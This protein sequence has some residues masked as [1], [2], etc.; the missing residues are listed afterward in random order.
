MPTAS[1]YVKDANG[2]LVPAQFLASP[3]GQGYITDLNKIDINP[4]NTKNGH[5]YDVQGIEI[6][7]ANPNNYLVVPVGFNIN[8]AIS[9]GNY[10]AGL[11]TSQQLTVMIGS[12]VGVGQFN[13]QRTYTD[14]NGVYVQGG[15]TVPMFQDASSYILGVASAPSGLTNAAI[16]GGGL[17]NLSPFGGSDLSGTWWNNPR[18]VISINAGANMAGTTFTPPTIPADA[19]SRNSANYI[20]DTSAN[21]HLV[22]IKDGG[23]VWDAYVQQKNSAT[24]FKDWNEY[25]TAA[26]ASNPGIADLNNVPAGTTFM[27]PEKFADGSITYNYAGGAA[28]NSNARTGEYYMVVPNTDDGGGQTVYS[29]TYDGNGLGGEAYTVRQ[30]STDAQGDTTYDFTGRQVG[31]DSDIKPITVIDRVAPGYNQVLTDSNA[32]GKLDIEFVNTDSNA[33]QNGTETNLYTLTTTTTTT[34]LGETLTD[35]TSAGPSGVGNNLLSSGD[36]SAGVNYSLL[37]DVNTTGSNSAYFNY[38]ITDGLRP[39]NSNLGL[40]IN[41]SSGQ[42]LKVPTTGTTLGDY[43]LY[44]SSLNNAAAANFQLT[45]TDPLVLDL[46]GDGVRLTNYSDSAVLFDADNDGGSLEQTGWVSALDGIVVQDL[47]GN[48][49]IDNISETLSEYYNGVA[50]SAGVAGTKPYANGFAALKSLDSNSDNQFTSLDAAWNNLRVW[51]DANHDGKTDAGELKTFA[52]LGITA[53]NLATTAQSGEVRDGNEVLALGSFTQN[54]LSREA[55]AANFLANPAGST[56]TQTG[57][58]I[59]IATE[60]VAGGAGGTGTITSFVSQ[61]TLSTVNETLDAATLGVRHLTGGAGADTLTGDTQNNW[62]AGGLGADKLYGGAG[63]DVLLIDANDAV[64]D[65]GTGLDI[66]QVVGGQLGSAGVTLNLSQSNIEIAVG[67]DG[68]DV[69]IGGGRSSVFVRGGAGD[70]LIIGGAANDV[71]SGED[72]SDL[73]DGGAGNDLIRGHRGQDQ[74]L[75]GAGDDVLDGGLEDDSLSGGVGNDV[76][77]GGRGDDMM[78]GGDGIDVAEYSGSYADYR[79][80]KVSNANGSNTFRVVDTRT[81]QDGADTLSNIEKLSFSDVSRVDLTLGSPLPV[82]DILSVNSTGQALSRT[83]AHLLSKTQLLG[84][85]RDWD[86]DTSQLSITAVLEAKGGT[87]TLTAQG[88]VLFT[89]DATYTGVMGFKYKVQDAQGNYTQVTNSAT[90]QTEAMK[91][92]VYLQTADLP[93]DPLAMEQWYLTDTNVLAAWGTAAEQAAGQGYSGK[94]IKIG[95]FEPGG[96]F[97]TGPEVFDYRHPDLAQNADKAWLNTLDSQGNSNVAQTFSTHATMVA[98]VMVAARNGQGGVGVAYNASLAGQ[99]I[100]GTGLEVSQLTAE[101]T[102]ALAKFKNYDVVNNSWGATSNFQINV[103]PVGLL[104]T[105]ILDAVTNGR[106]GLGTAIVMAGGNDRATGANT[107]TNALTANR[108]VITTGSINAPGDLGTLQIGSKPFSNPGASILVSAPGSNIDSTSRELIG[109]NGSTFGSDYNTAQGTSFAAPI[110]S[111]VIALMLEANPKLG[112]RDIQSI[113]A[114]SAT[115]FDDPNGTDWTYNTA[116]NWN[117]GGMHASHDYGFGKV[118]ARAAVRLAET[119]YDTSIAANEQNKTASSGTINATIPD[120]AGVL[121]QTLAMAAGLDVESAQVTLQLAHQRWGDLII[122]LISPTGTESVLVNRPGKAPGSAA[123]DLGD[124]STGT[125]SFSFN[126]THVRGEASGGNWTLQVLDAATGNTGTLT[127]WK[128]DLYG[129]TADSDDVYVYTNEFAST[130]GRTTLAD[131]NGGIDIVNAS[132]VTGNSTINLNNGTSSTIAGKGLT[133]SGDVEKAYGGDGNDT[134]TGN[135]LTNVLLGGRGNDTLNGGAGTDRLQG[136]RGNDTLTGGTERDWFVIQKDAGS[137]DTITD[138]T[139]TEVGEKIALVGFENVT[140]FSQVIVTQEGANTRLNLGGGQSVLLLNLAPSQISEQNFVFSSDDAS[141]DTYLTYATKALAYGTV[142]VDNGLLPNTAGDLAM[143]ALAGDDVLGAQTTNDLIDGG[144]GND[145]LWGDYPGY[146]PV[147]GSDW[148]EGGAGNDV[149]RGGAGNDRLIGGS[150]NDQLLGEDGDDILIGNT[151]L[152]YIDGGAGNDLIAMEGDTGTVNGTTFGYYGTRV[153]GAGADVFKVLSSGGGSAGFSA[154]GTQ[155]TASNLIAD[156]DPN[157]AGEKIDVSAF[158]WITN[159]SD[160]AIQNMTINGVQFARVSVSNGSQSLN[161]T[162]R[163]VTSSQLNASHFVFAASTPGAING[164]IS[165]DTLTGDAGANTINGMAGADSMT[166]RTGDDTYFVDNVGD[167]IN[168]LPGGGYDGV[169]SSVSYALSSDVEVLTLTGSAD[170]NAT[171]NAQRNRLVGN[172]GANRLDG[173]SEADDMLGDA[174][175]DAYVVDNQLDTAYENANE[176]IDVVESSVSWT[177]GSNFENLTLTGAGNINATGNDV[178]NV[179]T[180]NAADNIL[181]GAQGA[182]TMA[183]GIGN[184]TYYVDNTGDIV[185]EAIDAG[186]D[187]V[188]SSVDQIALAANVENAVLF[189]F[190]TTVNGNALDN[191]LVGNGLANSLSGGAGNDVLDGGTGADI[192][193]G[194]MGDDTFFV[195]NAGDSVVEL[196]GEGTDTV[197]AS[198]DTSLAALSANVENL[199]LTGTNNLSGTGNALANQISGNS[200][201]NT[202]TGGAGNDVLDGGAGADSMVGGI[203]DDTFYVDQSGDLVSESAG[204]GTDLVVSAVTYALGA[205]LENLTLSGFV[206]I[207]ATGNA[208]G[209]ILQGNSASNVL[210]GGAGTDSLRGNGGADTLRGGLDNDTYVF[211]LGDGQD[212]IEENDGTVGNVDTISFA[213]GIVPASITAS[214]IGGDLVLQ[215]SA[216][217]SVTVKGWYTSSAQKIE[218]IFFA[219]SGETLN[220]AQITAL[221]NHTPTGTV[222]IAGTTAQNQ[223][224]TAVNTLADIEGMGDVSYQWQASTDGANWTLIDGATSP[225]LSLTQAH[226]GKQIRVVGSY[227]DGQGAPEFM[228]SS[229][230]TAIVNINDAPLQSGTQTPLAAGVE[231]TSY[232]ITEA[233][234]LAGFTD[235]DGDALSVVDLT[236]SNGTLSAFDAVARSWTFNPNANYNGT[237]DI[238]YGVSDGVATPVA[239]THSFVLTATNDAPTGGV[240]LSGTTTENQTLSATNSLAD[241]DGMGTLG[242]QWQSSGDGVTWLAIS[243]ANASTFTLTGLQVGKQVRVNVNY[244]DGQGTLESITSASTA[245]VASALNYVVG[246]SAADTLTGSVGADSMQGLAGNDTYVVN[247]VGDIVIEALNAGTDIV[248]ASISYALTD[249]VEN[250]TLTGIDAINGTGNTL[251]NAITGNS[252]DNVLDGGL[253]VDTMAGGLGND[254]YYVDNTADVTTEAASAGIDTVI[255]SV[256]RTLATN[257]ENLVLIGTANLNGTGNTLVNTITGNSGNNVLNGGT[258]ADTLIGG[259]GDD[260]YVV[261]NVG[262]TVTELAGEGVDTIQS[263]VTYALGANVENLTLTGTGAINATGN[264]QSNVLLGNAGNNTLDG[265]LG[266]DTMKGGAGNDTYVVEDL[267]DLVTENLN[268]GTDTIKSTLSYVLGANLENL[269]L[270]GVL[271]INATGNELVNTLTGNAGDN[272]LNGMGGADKLLGGLGNDTY[273]IDNVGVVVT[274]SASSGTDTVLAS[275][276]LTLATNVEKLILMGTGNLNGTGNTLANSITG[277]SGNNVLNGGTGADTLTG[278]LGDDTYVV[279]N[280][281]DLVTEFA[282][283]GIDTVQ[284]SVTYTLTA[285]VENMTLTGTSAIQATGNALD[286]IL[287]GNGGNNTLTGGGGNDTLNGGAGT[288]S[289]VGGV[290]S[291]TYQFGLGYGADTITENDATAGN[292][293]VLQFL[294]GIASDQI[295]LRQV[296]NNLE[297]SV[298]GTTDKATVSNWYLGSQYHVEQ[299]KTS[300]GKT[301]LDSQVQN[302]VNAMSAFSPPAVGQTTL[303]ANY[304]TSLQPVITANWQ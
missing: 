251:N 150:G 292:A 217:D 224:L 168:E 218:Q 289:L 191:T 77:I 130:T 63:D 136:G 140:D 272:V 258:G 148:L 155:F 281:G 178:A 160:L 284:S 104:E 99:Y 166:G 268:E 7:N 295:W 232:T 261:D 266:S 73:I 19:P 142:G 231:D 159:L 269:T 264:A 34:A 226:V 82:K 228:N 24:G 198:V 39:G 238:S 171:G 151:G 106:G 237:V 201:N 274:E 36:Y 233:S 162:I 33:S 97:S 277:N 186:I 199:V 122:K 299:F 270:T 13:L 8:T 298:I 62:L 262:D 301:L 6:I 144:D 84:N 111:G 129:A 154:S 91:A 263:S 5:Y 197:V 207:D 135:A 195:D 50:G 275:V 109:D 202:L 44:G 149:L 133:I 222:S 31:L 182:D 37:G 164:T 110:V 139:P 22:V 213:S 156:F 180:G 2:K 15:T 66:A 98:G 85:D 32:D 115:K 141:L 35:S 107:N 172:A 96:A 117:G 153:G 59:T 196:A 146:S 294:S 244:T 56:V 16:K 23:K 119:W 242:Y 49:K 123:T 53:I 52:E 278:G 291:D 138:F 208:V 304:A 118:D 247:H 127:N 271:N 255:S 243:G 214:R 131:S 204:E 92:A 194:G 273:I 40:N 145:T 221:I 215:Y 177:L 279:D 28:I 235:G 58:G 108:A 303:A 254:T 260:T 212:S 276:D 18:N 60:N 205:N 74:L 223:T 280:A 181:D 113:L 9:F 80:T 70:D 41:A 10:V 210:D 286:N 288:D 300:D 30:I 239:A 293:D 229:A 3:N 29:R 68:N 241:A 219:D 132:A 100:Q 88:D 46:N 187:T 126:T 175:N 27:Q 64:I 176:G 192:M 265:G 174:G 38:G 200:G 90:G 184:D 121:S 165:N 296:A 94:G 26:A 287:M 161:L 4:I 290:G 1:F 76:L 211:A 206:N 125:L 86:S 250:L 282:N 45:P 48:G 116:K 81:G 124:A 102:S 72:G 152:D 185:T 220:A 67:G 87:A 252:A 47:N 57:S 248:Q 253:G 21:D 193:S 173:G 43:S 120:G 246:T 103:T 249:N 203:G 259:L 79:I 12:F 179:L 230:T 143:F 42:G 190:A 163:G 54:G 227:V 55:I 20:T 83:A 25:Q 256:T 93:T 234:L 65:G 114:M 216:N 69:F 75:G 105:G 257:I 267:G 169:Q 128:L 17:Y 78:D 283:E 95:Q 302:L 170:L 240:T 134:L 189:G 225:V 11:N 245:I 297:V 157:Q 285:N 112:Y 71:L 158:T 89:P 51:Q 167:T 61:N 209:N 188:Y 147:P 183:G 101:I 137:T 14:I 236:A